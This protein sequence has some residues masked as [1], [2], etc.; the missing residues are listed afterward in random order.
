MNNTD[1]LQRAVGRDTYG[2]VFEDDGL[3]VATDGFRLH[4]TNHGRAFPNWQKINQDIGEAVVAICVDAAF[5]RDALPE[6]GAVVLVAREHKREAGKH[7]IEVG[8]KDSRGDCYAVIMPLERRNGG[9]DIWRP[10][11]EGEP[12]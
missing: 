6:S 11:T 4:A 3:S 2:R 10:F 5:L 9:N 7:V 8:Y 12:E 1:F